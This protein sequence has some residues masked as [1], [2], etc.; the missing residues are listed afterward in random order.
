[1]F[2]LG[3]I[4]QPLGQKG[5]CLLPERERRQEEG[6]ILRLW[7]GG[8]GRRIGSILLKK[9]SILSPTGVARDTSAP[10]SKAPRAILGPS[11]PVEGGVINGRFLVFSRFA[12]VFRLCIHTTNKIKLS[13]FSTIKYYFSPSVKNKN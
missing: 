6:G 1:M 2:A 5:R 9:T 10:L 13:N 8:G 12:K 4:H 7:I 11:L 3:L